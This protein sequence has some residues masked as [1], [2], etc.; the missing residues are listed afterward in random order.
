MKNNWVLLIA[1]YI[2]AIFIFGICAVYQ[3]LH[4]MS[5]VSLTDVELQNKYYTEETI[6]NEMRFN[7]MWEYTESMTEEEYYNTFFKVQHDK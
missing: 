1:I 2:V 3:Q 7:A 4:A 5:A 6:K